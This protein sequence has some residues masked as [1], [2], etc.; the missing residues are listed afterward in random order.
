MRLRPRWHSMASGLTL[1]TCVPRLEKPV[2]GD[3][4]RSNDQAVVPGPRYHDALYVCVPQ[5]ASERQILAG[6][7]TNAR[8]PCPDLRNQLVDRKYAISKPAPHLRE[9]LAQ[10]CKLVLYRTV[11]LVRCRDVSRQVQPRSSRSPLMGFEQPNGRPSRH[12]QC[13]RWS[14]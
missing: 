6:F 1:P 3:D 10:C 8:A 13:R 12:P 14:P 11:V 7:F 5:H 4:S 2:D 9:P